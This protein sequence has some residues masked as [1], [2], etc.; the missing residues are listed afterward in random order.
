MPRRTRLTDV[1]KG[2]ILALKKEFVS[3]RDIAKTIHKSV[4]AVQNVLKAYCFNSRVQIVR[5]TMK[6]SDRTK[7]RMITMPCTGHYNA[8]DLKAHFNLTV[9]NSRIQQIISESAEMRYSNML[10]SPM[11]TV[12]HKIAR[13][14]W[15][16]RFVGREDPFWI[17][18]LFSDEKKFNLDDPDGIAYYW[19]SLRR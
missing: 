10:K 1:E 17:T 12:E 9:T 16:R 2:Q 6:I 8:N 5:K 11:L 4:E 3:Y 7:R 13:L 18:I 19:R 14:N 15:A